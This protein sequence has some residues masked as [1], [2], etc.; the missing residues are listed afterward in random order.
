[1][2]RVVISTGS[3]QYI[4]EADPMAWTYRKT[5]TFHPPTGLAVS[6]VSYG[7]A[8][9]FGATV[10]ATALYPNLGAFLATIRARVGPAGDGPPPA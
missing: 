9:P 6:Q 2:R 3:G 8:L 7:V 1:M 10:Q 4:T 5:G